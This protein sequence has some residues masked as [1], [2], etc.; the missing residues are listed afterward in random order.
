MNKKLYFWLVPGAFLMFLGMLPGQPDIVHLSFNPP[1]GGDPMRYVL[2]AQSRGEVWAHDDTANASEFTAIQGFT[3]AILSENVVGDEFEVSRSVLRFDDYFYQREAFDVSGGGGVDGDGGEEGGGEGL[4]GG[5]GGEGGGPGAGRPP[6]GGDGGGPGAGRPP[7][8]NDPFG[9]GAGRPPGGGGGGGATAPTP[10]SGE[11]AD[12]LEGEHTLIRNR[13]GEVL[14]SMGIDLELIKD[15]RERGNVS[16][17][18]LME[19]F[20][21]LRFPNSRV[22]LGQTWVAPVYLTIPGLRTLQRIDLEFRL[23]IRDSMAVSGQFGGGRMMNLPN[24]KAYRF[25]PSLVVDIFG[26]S[27]FEGDEED[28]DG[29]W[30][31]KRSFEGTMD[32]Q[33]RVYINSLTDELLDLLLQIQ[34]NMRVNE[35]RLPENE[36]YRSKTSLREIVSHGMSIMVCEERAMMGTTSLGGASCPIGHSDSGF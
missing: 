3:Q 2:R 16:L 14:T 19:Y 10:S 5:E 29:D 11:Y 32:L 13:N 36:A 33:G 7:S 27:A 26:H 15:E 21:I 9:G 31:T 18:Q 23:P 34:T 6:G 12:L 22:R 28:V 1:V 20:H 30:R 4:G 8:S 35:D 17:S 25:S 24:F